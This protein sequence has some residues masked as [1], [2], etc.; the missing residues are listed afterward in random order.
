VHGGVAGRPHR[1]A[2]EPYESLVAQVVVTAEWLMSEPFREIRFLVE[3]GRG[4]TRT[5]RFKA[6]SIISTY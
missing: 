6:G 5:F 4:R 1:A 3:S 2:H